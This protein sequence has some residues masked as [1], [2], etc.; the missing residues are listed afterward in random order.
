MVFCVQACGFTPRCA[1]EDD[2]SGELRV[3]KILRIIKECRFGIHDLSRTELNSITQL[4]RFNMPFELGLDFAHRYTGKGPHRTKKLLIL[5]REMFRYQTYLSDLAGVD[6]KAHLN[7]PHRL[8][9]IVNDWLRNQ[10]DDPDFPGGKDI[11]RLFTKFETELPRFAAR[12][13][14]NPEEL[15]FT[16][17]TQLI[18][19]WLERVVK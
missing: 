4:P 1:L 17:L 2:D 18:R 8:I 6:I 7:N 3:L 12:R 13:G 11:S 9:Q 14:H 19:Q 10:P 16:V 15:S 5:D